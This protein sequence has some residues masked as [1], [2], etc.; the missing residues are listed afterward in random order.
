[1][2]PNYF[3][4]G[5]K[6]LMMMMMMMMLMM[7][8]RHGL[9]S[10]WHG[11]VGWVLL[12]PFLQAN[13]LYSLLLSWQGAGGGLGRGWSTP[14]IYFF[15]KG[16]SLQ[17]TKFFS[18]N[19][20]QK[21]HPESEIAW[22]VKIPLS[23]IIYNNYRVGNLNFSALTFWA[24]DI[25]IVLARICFHLPTLPTPPPPPQKKKKNE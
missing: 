12:E 5:E 6:E 18:S 14:L 21:C 24:S 9:R 8:I 13:C 7:N 4:Y 23:A 16:S 20:V 19:F 1:M 22:F 2:V 25:Q 10:G 11:W 17:I 3:P 15:F